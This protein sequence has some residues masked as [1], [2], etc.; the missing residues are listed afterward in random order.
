MVEAKDQVQRQFPCSQCGAALHFEPGKTELDCPY[1]GARTPIATS[2][3][4]VEELDYELY[5]KGVPTDEPVA[6]QVTVVCSACGAA[7]ELGKNLTADKCVFCGSAVVVKQ[8]GRLIRPRGL[9]PFVIG[10]TKAHADFKDWVKGLWFA[11]GNLSG[12]ADCAPLHGV[13]LPFWTFDADAKTRYVGERGEDYYVTETYTETVNGRP[14]TRTREVCHTRWWPVSGMVENH[15]DDLLVMASAS[16]PPKQVAHLEPWDL[17]RLTPYA[18]EYLAGFAAES[19]QVDLP[20]G[21]ARAKQMAEPMIG[22]TVARDIGGDHQRVISM[23]SEY[24]NVTFKHILL[25]L[26]IS[27][28][29]YGGK[30]YRFVINARTGAVQGERPYSAWKITIFVLVILMVIA[31]AIAIQMHMGR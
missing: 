12:A 19:Y 4:P 16:L 23:N 11:P 9:L 21:F 1:C 3:E 31:L 27:A 30:S 17:E 7:T 2:N 20:N 13:Y 22:S 6:N 24:L 8:T 10:R 28:Y 15:F 29:R 14:E 18:E 26:W 25:P 5:V